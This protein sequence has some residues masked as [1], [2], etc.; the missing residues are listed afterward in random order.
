MS[1]VQEFGG[2]V[3]TEV[4]SGEIAG[5]ETTAQLPDIPCKL[6]NLKAVSTNAGSVYLG[7]SGVTIADG[8]TDTTTGLELDAGNSIWLPIDNLNSLYLICDNAGDDLTYL[9]LK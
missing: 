9:A 7:S 8:S 2:P 4:V 1:M 3:Y 5:S 6:V